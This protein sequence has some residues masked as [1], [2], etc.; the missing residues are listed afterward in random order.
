MASITSY[1]KK[2]WMKEDYSYY[3]FWFAIGMLVF[4]VLALGSTPLLGNGVRLVYDLLL[5]AGSL[6]GFFYMLATIWGELNLPSNYKRFGWLPVSKLVVCAI[7]IVLSVAGL[8]GYPTYVLPLLQIL[9][10]LSSN[11]LMTLFGRN[12]GSKSK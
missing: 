10:F 2:V 9:I 4:S 1:L 6:S 3:S 5:L 7:I 12:S 11:V 8:F